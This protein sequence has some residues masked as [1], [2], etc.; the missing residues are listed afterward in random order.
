[1]VRL[2]L[3]PDFI[4]SVTYQTKLCLKVRRM[5]IYVQLIRKFRKH[6]QLLRCNF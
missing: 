3:F 2:L 5:N 6:F 4:T 1:M